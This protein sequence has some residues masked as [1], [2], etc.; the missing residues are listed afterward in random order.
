MSALFYPS[1]NRCPSLRGIGKPPW[2]LWL[3][4]ILKFTDNCMCGVQRWGSYSKVMLNTI[5][6]HRVSPCNLLWE[7]LS[8]FVLFR[9]Y[10]NM[11]IG[12]L[13][14]LGFS[15]D[16]LAWFTNSFSDRVQCIK[17]EGLLSGPLAVSMGVPQGSILRPTVFSVYIND[18]ALAAGDSLIQLYAD[19][20][21]L[22]T[23]GPSLDTVLTTLQASFNAIQLSYRGLQLLL[24]T[25][26]TKCM[27]DRKSTRLNSSHHN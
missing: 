14:S 20:T 1:T 12:R 7:L 27:L 10:H 16:C 3:N 18:V 13:D 24:N 15:N 23:S 2:S 9:L 6:A 5:I 4:L 19:D 8:T 11:L 21:I 25:S 22:Y 26:K 17:S